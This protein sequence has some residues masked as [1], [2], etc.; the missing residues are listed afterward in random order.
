MG[1]SES[2]TTKGNNEIV[3]EVERTIYDNKSTPV[4]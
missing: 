3:E 4:M 2:H 1:V